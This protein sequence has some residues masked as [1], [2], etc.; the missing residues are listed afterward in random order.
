MCWGG[1]LGRAGW[2]LRGVPGPNESLARIIDN[3]RLGVEKFF[4]EI[5]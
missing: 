4:L 5:A 3:L 2:K 1:G